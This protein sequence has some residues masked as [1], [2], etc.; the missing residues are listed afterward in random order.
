MVFEAS[1]DPNGIPQAAALIRK[2]GDI[3]AVGTPPT[4]NVNIPLLNL[5]LNEVSIIGIRGRTHTSW[6][7]AINLIKKVN[8]API[9]GP[10]VSLD[11]ID[12]AFMKAMNREVIKIII[13]PN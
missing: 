3:I 9:I 6:G 12:E 7:R 11:A 5:I 10:T 8:V 2:G 4:E 1:G 13:K